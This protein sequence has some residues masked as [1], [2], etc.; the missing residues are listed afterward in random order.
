M[1]ENGSILYIYKKGIYICTYV[2]IYIRKC[3]DPLNYKHMY[4]QTLIY[5]RENNKLKFLIS[6]K[7]K[8][9]DTKD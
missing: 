2:F 6:Y 1:K 7:L 3:M 8:K 9:H 4:V 5:K